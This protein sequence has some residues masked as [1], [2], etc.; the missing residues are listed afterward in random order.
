[1]SQLL[2]IAAGGAFGAVA[3]HGMNVGVMRVMGASFPWGILSV[4]VLG[5]FLI[6]LLTALFLRKAPA[7]EMMP[8]FLMTGFLGG[9]TTF[10]GFAIDVVKLMQAGQNGLAIMYA[11]ASVVLS[12][13]AVFAGFV[14]L[15]AV[16]G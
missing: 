2:W 7:N 3:R 5:S 1:V 9:F 16:L 11:V 10:S 13:L 4:N 6:G 15:R 12:V 14:V 8:L